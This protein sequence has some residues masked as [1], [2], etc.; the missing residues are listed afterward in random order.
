MSLTRQALRMMLWLWQK[1]YLAIDG[2]IVGENV[3]DN[4]KLPGQILPELYILE[5]TV[6]L[7]RFSSNDSEGVK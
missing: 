6:K 2:G 1:Q 4:I 3:T 5:E 7:S